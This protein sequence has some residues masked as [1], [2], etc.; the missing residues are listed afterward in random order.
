MNVEIT[1]TVQ[2]IG[3]VEQVTDKFSKRDIIVQI[4]E[5]SQYPQLCKVQFSNV[6]VDKLNGIDVGDEVR[7]TADIRSSKLFFNQKLGRDDC[8]TNLNGWKVELVRRSRNATQ[9]N[10]NPSGTPRAA[11]PPQS[12][13]GKQQAA[14]FDDVPF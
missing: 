2:L 4:D 5:A 6:N 8:F 7:I 12:A 1:G 13:A 9:S 10:A 3:D 14:E 11:A